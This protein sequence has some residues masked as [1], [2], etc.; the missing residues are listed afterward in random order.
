MKKKTNQPTHVAVQVRQIRHKHH[1][2]SLDLHLDGNQSGKQ[3]QATPRRRYTLDELLAA[4]DYPP[5]QVKEDR[6]WVD[7]PPVGRELI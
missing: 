2:D 6:E 1:A 5:V 4:S 7:A 3:L